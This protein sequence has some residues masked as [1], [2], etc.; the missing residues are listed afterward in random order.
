MCSVR[1]SLVF[2]FY[3]SVWELAL[4]L[5]RF[6]FDFVFF[7]SF[8]VFFKDF[9]GFCYDFD[10]L[11]GDF[12]ILGILG[13]WDKCAVFVFHLSLSFFFLESFAESCFF[14]F[15]GGTRKKT[16]V[17]TYGKSGGQRGWD[18]GFPA[19]HRHHSGTGRKDTQNG[20]RCGN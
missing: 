14:S 7:L 20:K 6:P 9:D 2:E 19:L 8:F 12:D 13:I 17:R 18:L 4:A 11:G 1:F 16:Y 15:W 3:F 10:I 5:G